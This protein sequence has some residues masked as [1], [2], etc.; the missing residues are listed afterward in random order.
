M[1]S[2]KKSPGP[3]GSAVLETLDRSQLPRHLAVIMDGN[4]RWA[5]SRGWA[6]VRGHEE[7]SESV[8]VIVRSCRELGIAYLT[9]YAFSSENWARPKAEVAALMKLLTRF[10]KKERQ[11]MIDRS[12]RLNAIGD[13]ERLPQG[14]RRVLGETM[15]ATAKGRELT[16]TLALSYGG[17][18]EIVRA[19]RR[20]C[21]QAKAGE[22]DPASVSEDDLAAGLYTSDIPD[23]DL[24]IRTSGEQRLSNFLLWQSTYSELYFSEVLWPDF[25]EAQ[26]AEALKAYAFRE[27]RFGLTGEQIEGE[28][29][30]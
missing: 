13:L 16:L 17:R 12:I 5:K 4:G 3:G 28:Q 18:Q 23:P 24:L 30:E 19:A 6:R 21:K 25:R 29:D 27:R 20:L 8:R 7:G 2:N 11:E 22:L 14:V 26:L 10:L 1:P 15:D 9:V